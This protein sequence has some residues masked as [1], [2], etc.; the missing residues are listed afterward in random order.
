MWAPEA[1]GLVPNWAGLWRVMGV[2]GVANAILTSGLFFTDDG[3]LGCI[4][5]FTIHLDA[6]TVLARS[7]YACFDVFNHLDCSALLHRMGEFRCIQLRSLWQLGSLTSSRNRIADELTLGGETY[8]LI[9]W[10]MAFIHSSVGVLR[11]KRRE[12]YVAGLHIPASSV[13]FSGRY[14]HSSLGSTWFFT[15]VDSR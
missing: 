8:L 4:W 10:S 5:H 12:F 9:S 2:A 15:A 6:T 13:Q 14:L 1:C 3:V 11:G 7:S